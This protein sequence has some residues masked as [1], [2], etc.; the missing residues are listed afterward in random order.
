MWPCRGI[1]PS[2]SRQLRH[3]LPERQRRLVVFWGG[4]LAVLLQAVFTL[5]V[6]DL[7]HIPGLRLLGALLLLVIAC[8]LLQE[9]SAAEAP[10]AAEETI[11]F[12]TSIVRIALANVAMSF[13]NVVAVASVSRSDPIRM[14]LGL[15][16]SG[17]IIFVF[18]AA[19]VELMSR[20]KWIAYGGAALLAVTAAG[21][22]WHDLS[23]LPIGSKKTTAILEMAAI[24]GLPAQALF[25]GFVV[26][27]CLSSPHWGL[28]QACVDWRIDPMCGR[29]G[30]CS[31]KA[32]RDSRSGSSR[33][34]I[35]SES[36]PRKRAV[37]RALRAV[38]GLPCRP[39]AFG[40]TGDITR[41]GSSLASRR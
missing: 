6:A 39:D 4:A 26:M 32:T 21:M 29:T 3:K 41:R 34:V 20:F 16:I 1:T 25:T 40:P 30:L 27:A 10:E 31:I 2:S 24:H 5:L 33:G 19:I 36:S 22:M 28:A 8:K 38:R 7:L 23:S 17:L 18:S 14:G 12:G 11:G 37:D 35:Q 13:D 15:L 9:E